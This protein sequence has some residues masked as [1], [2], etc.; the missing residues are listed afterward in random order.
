MSRRFRFKVIDITSLMVGSRV[1]VLFRVKLPGED[2]KLKSFCLRS[3]MIGGNPLRV[4]VPR[5]RHKSSVVWSLIKARLVSELFLYLK[6][7]FFPNHAFQV[8]FFNL[9][10]LTLNCKFTALSRRLN[11]LLSYKCIPIL[12]ITKFTCAHLFA[13]L[14]SIVILVGELQNW[15]VELYFKE[16]LLNSSSKKRRIGNAFHTLTAGSIIELPY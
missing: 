2:L 15:F 12:L 11:G 9:T 3:A 7:Y 16:S 1:S 5:A 4:A 8:K 6:A 14:G 10:P 13:K